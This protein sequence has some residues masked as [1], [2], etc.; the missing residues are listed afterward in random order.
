MEKLSGFFGD[1]E[2]TKERW[3]HIT[4]FHPEVRPYRKYFFVPES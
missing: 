3:A 2:L 1:I 4:R